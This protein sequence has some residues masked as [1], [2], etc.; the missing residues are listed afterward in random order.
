M[1]LE[2]YAKRAQEIMNDVLSIFKVDQGKIVIDGVY[3]IKGYLNSKRIMWVLKE[4]YAD[5]RD[6]CGYRLF[7][8]TEWNDLVLNHDKIIKHMNGNRT[9]KRIAQISF[10][11]KQG[12]CVKQARAH[13][14]TPEEYVKTLR[15]VGYVNTGKVIGT[16]SSTPMSRLRKLYKQGGDI[17]LSQMA[18][19]KPQ[20]VIF[21]GTFNVY[22]EKNRFSPQGENMY[23]LCDCRW[24]NPL[25]VSAYHPAARVNQDKYFESILRARNFC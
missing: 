16:S 20:I 2:M 6:D 25:I 9:L 17:V 14:L 12:L 1:D 11:L 23:K 22:N 4:S 19:Y 5:G 18:L 24:G 7:E 10:A 3:D 8:D 13:E 21:A 15:S